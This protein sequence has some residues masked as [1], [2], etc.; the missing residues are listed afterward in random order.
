MQSK[1][2]N[3]G[4][5]KLYYEICKK[6]PMMVFL[7]G[8]TCNHTVFKSY[9]DHFHKLGA[10]FL[11][12]DQ[13]GHGKSSCPLSKSDYTLEAYTA[14]LEKILKTEKIEKMILVGHSL[15]TIV[16]QNYTIKYPNNVEALILISPSYNFKKTFE[17]SFLRKIFLGLDPLL[18][19]LLTRYNQVRGFT[20][21]KRK[22]HYIDFSQEK[23]KEI[24]D[25]DFLK[26][27]YGEDTYKHVLADHA[28]GRAIMKWD[29]ESIV[30]KIQTPTLIV[31]GDADR[32]VSVKSAYKLYEMIPGAER[33][34]IIP[35]LR[36]GLVFRYP[37]LIIDTIEEFLV[38]KNKLSL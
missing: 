33:P 32:L 26:K 25:I 11:T 23:I 1:F 38:K 20:N 29:I 2:V 14:D 22:R 6:E 5:I 30:S 16:A 28:M 7:H 8:G 10:G 31:H 36:H 24:S 15:G 19:Q 9:R 37:K 12:F 21:F 17:K 34:V 18:R 27:V 3:N 4:K 35:G 13:R